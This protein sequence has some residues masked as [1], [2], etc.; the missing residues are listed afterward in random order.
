MT[1]LIPNGHPIGLMAPLKC[2]ALHVRGSDASSILMLRCSFPAMEPCTA[3]SRGHWY[4]M[5]EAAETCD[6][7]TRN[8]L[9]QNIC[10]E[11]GEGGS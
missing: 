7:W 4:N 9:E 10:T 8:A 2:P 6:W 1:M 3:Y 5:A 11:N